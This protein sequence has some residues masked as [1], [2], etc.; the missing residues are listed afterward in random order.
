MSYIV[1]NT[2]IQF[3]QPSSA[4]NQDV[5]VIKIDPD[6]PCKG[7]HGHTDGGGNHD[8]YVNEQ[9]KVCKYVQKR[10]IRMFTTVSMLV[11][12]QSIF[13]LCF[14]YCFVDCWHA[15]SLLVSWLGG[16]PSP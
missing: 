15:G 6:R 1:D 2:C 14:G 9:C 13:N 5:I 4:G 12:M 3:V 8:I 11:F 10:L 16:L 7:V